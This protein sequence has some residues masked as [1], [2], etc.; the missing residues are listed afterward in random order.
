MTHAVQPKT[1]NNSKNK[2]KKLKK[3]N[4]IDNLNKAKREQ[5]WTM[6]EEKEDIIT[7]AVRVQRW[8]QGIHN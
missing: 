5:K 1:Q 4:K 2:T 7:G 8:E 6:L 3:T